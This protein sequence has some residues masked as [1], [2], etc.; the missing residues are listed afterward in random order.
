MIWCLQFEKT[1]L[2]SQKHVKLNT[3]VCDSFLRDLRSVP[4]DT[5]YIYDNVDDLWDH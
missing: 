5:A 2:Q 4:W 1:N 3:R